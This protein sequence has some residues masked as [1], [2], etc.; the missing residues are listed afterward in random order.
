MFIKDLIQSPTKVN[1]QTFT[2]FRRHEYASVYL[3]YRTQHSKNH[4]IGKIVLQNKSSE[5][6]SAKKHYKTH[7]MKQN[8]R[9][10]QTKV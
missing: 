8:I 10:L 2:D 1:R 3:C 4:S 7:Q 9:Y 6:N 5:V